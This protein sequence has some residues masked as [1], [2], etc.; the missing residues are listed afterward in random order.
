MFWLLL[1]LAFPAVLIN[2]GHGQNGFLTAALLGGALV[3][4]D[5]RPLVAGILI[6]LL[7]YKPQFGLMI[8]LALLAERPLARYRRRGRDG[9][10]ADARDHDRVRSRRSGMPSSPRRSSRAPSCSNR[11]TTGWHKIQSV[12]SWA[13]MW[14]A[15]IPLAYALQGALTLALGAAIVWL[16]RGAASAALKARRFASPRSSPRPIR[17]IT[18]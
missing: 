2:I 16:W 15:P 12:F 4:L 1:A 3:V 9:H 17:S 10:S 5:R 6:G 7:V 8:P 11:A 18:T 13:R 14:G